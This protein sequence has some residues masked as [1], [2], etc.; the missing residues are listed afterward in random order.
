MRSHPITLP[1]AV[2]V[3]I[4]STRKRQAKLRLLENAKADGG[5][6]A[7]AQPQAANSGSL[8]GE[9]SEGYFSS[10]QRQQTLEM[11]LSRERVLSLLYAKVTY[12]HRFFQNST[13][14]LHCWRVFVVICGRKIDDG[15]LA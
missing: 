10:R 12:L 11:L 9:D 14:V 13:L 3:Q 2:C 6:G 15:L 7:L 1:C 8:E 4:I 5:G